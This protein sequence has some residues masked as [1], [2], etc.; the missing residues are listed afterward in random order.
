VPPAPPVPAVP[1]GE[2]QLTLATWEVMA[3]LLAD[4]KVVALAFTEGAMMYAAPE[5][6]WSAPKLCPISC[7][8]QIVVPR[9]V[10]R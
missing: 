8:A 2:K 5:A 9:P 10:P 6:S 1:H 4:E 7:A 3:D